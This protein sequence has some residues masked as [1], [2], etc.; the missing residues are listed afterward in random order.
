MIAFLLLA[1]PAEA[2][3]CTAR[4]ILV[5][6][7]ERTYGQHMLNFGI[8]RDGALIETWVN[9][10]RGTYSIVKSQTTGWACVISTGHSFQKVET[11]A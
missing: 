4:N 3:W 9:W 6:A 1:L 5:E 8:D 10:H 2:M 11:R 7:L